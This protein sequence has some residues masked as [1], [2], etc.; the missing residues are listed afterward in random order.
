MVG[1]GPG[2]SCSLPPFLHPTLDGFAIIF[3]LEIIEKQPTFFSKS[4]K[5]LKRKLYLVAL[6]HC[7][8]GSLV[9]QIFRKANGVK[10]TN[11]VD[12]HKQ[13]FQDGDRRRRSNG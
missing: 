3:A 12:L 4:Y 1:W 6:V 5:Y 13:I 8:S 9:K 7:C 10:N 2:A 11:R